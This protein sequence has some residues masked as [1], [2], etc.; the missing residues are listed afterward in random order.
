MAEFQ[1]RPQKIFVGR[2][3]LLAGKWSFLSK[4]GR[5]EAEKSVIV[6]YRRNVL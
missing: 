4:S 2:E 5:K 6:I 1:N 3:K